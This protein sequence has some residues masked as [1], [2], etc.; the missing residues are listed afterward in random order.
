MSWVIVINESNKIVSTGV[1]GR[2]T[3]YAT[4][5]AAKA[6][7]TR[8]IKKQQLTTGTFTIYEGNSMPVRT[9][10][11]KNLLTGADVV[12]DV[13]TPYCCSVASESYWSN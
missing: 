1:Y 4:E 11:V 13:N 5:R 10:V 2:K 7:A 6:G 9:H 8:L 3:N 12:E